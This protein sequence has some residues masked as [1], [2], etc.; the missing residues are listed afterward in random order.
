MTKAVDD[1]GWR[2]LKIDGFTAVFG[3][4]L[5]K[6]LADGK[7]RYGL[8]TGARHVN[9][10]GLVHGG[11][12]TSFL[13]QVIALDAWTAADRAPVV[14]VQIDTRFLSAARQGDFLEAAT[15]IRHRTGSMIFLDADVACGRD[16]VATATSIM[17]ITK[18]AE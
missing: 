15:K 17:K 2:A 10:I 6:T 3:P 4:V 13:D 9:L 8:Q 12:I 1:R 14:T 5:R 7:Q 11:V 18:K 16:L